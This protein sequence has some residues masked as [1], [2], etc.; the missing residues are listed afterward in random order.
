MTHRLFYTPDELAGA[1][2]LSGETIR[3]KLR[4]GQWQGVRIGDAWRV[5]RAEVLHL[6]GPVNLDAFDAQLDLQAAQ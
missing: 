3:R 4:T 6:I 5:P 1:L 2:R